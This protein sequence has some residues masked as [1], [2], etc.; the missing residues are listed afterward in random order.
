MPPL[1]LVL[2]ALKL[3]FLG[4][5]ILTLAILL[6]LDVLLRANSDQRITKTTLRLWLVVWLIE[7]AVPLSLHFTLKLHQG[8]LRLTF[9]LFGLAFLT[10]LS[11]MHL[12]SARDHRKSA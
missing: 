2:M 10:G 6:G 7:A 8:I 9:L 1:I 12:V 4:T 3:G 11:V 5:I